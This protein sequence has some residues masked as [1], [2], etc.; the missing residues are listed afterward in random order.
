MTEQ[1]LILDDPLLAAILAAGLLHN[2]VA[3]EDVVR[4]ADSEIEKREDIPA[5]LIDLSMSQ[6]MF[7]LDIISLLSGIAGDVPHLA[8]CRGLYSL[9]GDLPPTYSYD[10]YA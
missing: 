7:T 5:W 3:R 6:K 2:V 10:D 1:P 4:W 8:V 9:F